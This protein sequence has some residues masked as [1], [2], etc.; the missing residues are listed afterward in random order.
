[1]LIVYATNGMGG[2]GYSPHESCFSIVGS[3]FCEEAGSK[4]GLKLTDI[5]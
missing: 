1:M 4:I 5:T 2:M 3:R